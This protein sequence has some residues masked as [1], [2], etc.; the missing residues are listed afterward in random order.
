MKKMLIHFTKIAILTGFLTLTSCASRISRESI[1]AN[2]AHRPASRNPT[3][4]RHYNVAKDDWEFERD[5]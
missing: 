4:E 2:S 1:T 3:T 5:W